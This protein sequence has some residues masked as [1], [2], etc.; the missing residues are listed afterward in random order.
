VIV[1]PLEVAMWLTVINDRIMRWVNHIIVLSMTILLVC[2][3]LQIANRFIFKLPM[4]W[5]QEFARIFFAWLVFFA[6]AKAI[7]EKSH[8]FVDILEVAVKGKIA[9]SFG[10]IADIVS[11]VFFFILLAVGLPWAMSNMDV[12]TETIP[13]LSSGIFLLCIPIT[14][15]LMILFGSEVIMQ[16]FRSP[17]KKKAEV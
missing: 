1:S 10:M 3:T 14:A 8:I 6:S 4:A 2:I 12:D 5:T 16:R 7:R 13:G 9:K 17:A 11:I 15:L